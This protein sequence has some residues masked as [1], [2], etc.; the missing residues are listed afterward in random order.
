MNDLHA[1]QH[2]II[3]F[4]RKTT[5]IKPENLNKEF[6]KLKDKLVEIQKLPY[7]KRPFLYLDIIS[8]LQ[9]KLD[10]IIVEKV[11]ERNFEKTYTKSA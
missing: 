1:V 6:K 8:W 10:G 4:L 2:E 3:K 5:K 9:S 7:E 11:I